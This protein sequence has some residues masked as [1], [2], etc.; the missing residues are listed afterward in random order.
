MLSDGEVVEKARTGRFGHGFAAHFDHGDLSGFGGDAS[1]ADNALM[2]QLAF[3]CS[4]DAAQMERIFSES[5]LGQRPKWRNRPNY[6]RDT[7][8]YAIKHNKPY[9]PEKH[10]PQETKVRDRLAVAADYARF[11]H[12]WGEITGTARS[13]STDYFAFFAFLRKAHKANSLEVDM[14]ERDLKDDA[15][16]G[17]NG[18]ALQSLARLENLHGWLDKV[19]D[20]DHGN[21]ARYRIKAGS[22]LY[23]IEIQGYSP[24]SYPP[25]VDK[26]YG[27]ET[28]LR[29][30]RHP[31]PATDKTH[32]KNGRKLPKGPSDPLRSLG[33]PAAMVL[34][35]AQAAVAR[36][37]EVVPVLF[38]AARIG[39]S[40]KN[41]KARQ[42]RDLVNAGLLQDATAS[43]EPSYRIPDDVGETLKR[44]LENSG[45]LRR[46]EEGRKRTQAER[47]V[48]RIRY[49]WWLGMNVE[50]IEAATGYDPDEIAAVLAPPAPAP[51]ALEME[52][53]R[54]E[55][56]I[57]NASGAYAEL[58]KE[59]PFWEGEFPAP[60]LEPGDT[61]PLLGHDY[62]PE[63]TEAPV[64][65]ADA[66]PKVEV[67]QERSAELGQAPSSRSEAGTTKTGAEIVA[68]FAEAVD[69][70]LSCDCV[71]CSVSA[72][73]FATQVVN[74]V[75]YRRRRERVA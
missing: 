74:L 23:H 17:N 8:A 73:R 40:L 46:H 66:P 7:V 4:H 20:G 22:F 37:G 75:E 19:R 67:P 61:Q 15:G 48:Q 47:R 28:I 55:R 52:Q 5:A 42:G 21:A 72:P 29:L 9:T 62:S 68:E 38:L 25:C 14:S 6:R 59:S 16:L 58:V 34:D 27:T 3:W 32:D 30:I 36:T 24:L 56:E 63:P 50:R 12:P 64:T 33:K 41:F 26:T 35:I 18:T 49:L 10:R 71:A 43:G 53:E 1:R 70:S 57:R 60:T 65:A 45:A 31:S 39:T 51:T 2:G 69:H 44:E 54:H 11:V 13:A